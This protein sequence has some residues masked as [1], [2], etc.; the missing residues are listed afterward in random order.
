MV[1]VAIEENLS[2]ILLCACGTYFIA[3]ERFSFGV[4]HG[5]SCL[6]LWSLDIIEL[7]H[8]FFGEA[9]AAHLGVEYSFVVQD[10]GVCFI[11]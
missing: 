2:G 6:L 7:G 1:F 8:F 3:L 10:E 11:R 5:V 9:V 4:W